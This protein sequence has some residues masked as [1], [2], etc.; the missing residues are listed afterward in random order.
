MG[1]ADARRRR[2]NRLAA[3]GGGAVQLQ[4]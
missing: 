2:P 3:E 4:R 1:I